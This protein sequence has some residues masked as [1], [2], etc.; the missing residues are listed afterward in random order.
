[1]EFE[2]YSYRYGQEILEHPRHNIVLNEI[3]DA[4]RNCPLYLYP[5]KSRNNRDLE[6]RS[7]NYLIFISTGDFV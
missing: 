5:N 7:N 6:C 3:T 4:I 2:I 1:M